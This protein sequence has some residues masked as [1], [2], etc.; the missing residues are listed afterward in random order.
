MTML[1]GKTRPLI[2]IITPTF[3]ARGTLAETLRSVEG[4]L[5]ERTEHLLVDACSDDG[6][7]EIARKADWLKISSEPDRGIYDGMN[8]GVASASGEWLLFL[9]ADDWLPDGTLEAYRSAI[10]NYPD[11]VVICG[12]AEAIKEV[13]GKWETVWSVNARESKKLTIENVA[14]GEPMINARLIR[15]ETFMRHGG[16]SLDYSLASDRDFLLR[17]AKEGIS[18]ANVPTVT[19]RYRWHAGSSTMTEGNALT[20]RLLNENLAIA[21]RHLHIAKGVERDVLI[22]WHTRLTLQ[23]AMNALESGKLGILWEHMAAGVS[24]DPLWPVLFSR[25][26]CRSLPGFV[27]RGFRSRSMVLQKGRSHE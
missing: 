10:T 23:G 24:R 15:R 3:N 18:Q 17:T 11:A 6:T 25:E 21:R 26:I 13:N 12:S 9:Q 1:P 19:Y 8:K 22:R 7:L 2:S 4:Q 16:F 20:D 14:L 5:D 27:R